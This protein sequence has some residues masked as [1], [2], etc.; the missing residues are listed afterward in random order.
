[1]Y[2]PL[3]S[4]KKNPIFSWIFFAIKCRPRN[5]L[6]Y[7]IWCA[8]WVSPLRQNIVKYTDFV[9]YGTLPPPPQ[10][11]YRIQYLFIFTEIFNIYILYSH[12]EQNRSKTFWINIKCTSK[13][14]KCI[15]K[16]NTLHQHNTGKKIKLVFHGAVRSRPDKNNFT[17]TIINLIEFNVKFFI[18]YIVSQLTI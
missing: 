18:F 12:T 11:S 17:K 6:G 15:Y 7:K 9:L 8:R 10:P 2:P 4:F 14:K 3:I 13:K 16:K 1:M 5:H